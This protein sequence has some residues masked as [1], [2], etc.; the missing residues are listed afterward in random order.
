MVPELVLLLALFEAEK[1]HYNFDNFDHYK[2]KREHEISQVREQM[3]TNPPFN[4]LKKLAERRECECRVKIFFLM[5]QAVD[6]EGIYA[7]SAPC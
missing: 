4:I 2:I 6:L 3:F 5:L 1:H 7:P